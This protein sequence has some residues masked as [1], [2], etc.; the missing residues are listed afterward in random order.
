MHII[1]NYSAQKE[2]GKLPSAH[3]GS[4]DED[5]YFLGEFLL[6]SRKFLVV[7]LEMRPTH[8]LMKPIAK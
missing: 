5:D 6:G 7:W 4:W 1:R 2:R 8:A 3:C